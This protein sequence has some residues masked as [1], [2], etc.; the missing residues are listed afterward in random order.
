MIQPV[1]FAQN[2]NT[3][4]KSSGNLNKLQVIQNTRAYKL[5]SKQTNKKTNCFY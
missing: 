5:L 4:N 2:I 3:E 1:S